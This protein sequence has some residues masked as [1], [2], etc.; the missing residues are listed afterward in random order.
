MGYTV[1]SFNLTCAIT[2][3]DVPGVPGIPTLPPRIPSQICALVYGR[4][5][6]VMSTGGTSIPGV[7]IQA[8]NLLLPAGTDI[9]GPQDGNS[10]DMVELPPLSQQWYQVCFVNDVG[11]G[12]PNEHRTAAL[13][14]LA[15]T[16]APPYV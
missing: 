4:R 2:S 1:P 12:W 15:G 5:V 8:I 10:F 11:K 7:P 9:R 16:W 3:P 13:F 6:N 14:A